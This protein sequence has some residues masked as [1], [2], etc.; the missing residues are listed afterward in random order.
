MVSPATLGSTPRPSPVRLAALDKQPFG[1]CPRLI[2]LLSPK[3][4]PLSLYTYTTS[5]QPPAAY[6]VWLLGAQTRPTCALSCW[7]TCFKT[8]LLLFA[9]LT[10]YR[11]RNCVEAA[12]SILPIRSCAR[13]E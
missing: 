7:M 1:A 12:V 11:K 2:L 5:S 13:S 6:S 3:L 10:S 4:V 8:G 9:P